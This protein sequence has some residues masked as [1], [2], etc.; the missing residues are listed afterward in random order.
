M[1]LNRNFQHE[2]QYKNISDSIRKLADVR[3]C[4]DYF[5]L[6]NKKKMMKDLSARDFGT[7]N[8][9]INSTGTGSFGQICKTHLHVM[10]NRDSDTNLGDYVYH[11]C[12]TRKSKGAVLAKKINFGKLTAFGQAGVGSELKGLN[13]D[14]QRKVL[15]QNLFDSLVLRN[16]MLVEHRNLKHMEGQV[17]MGAPGG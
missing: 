13:E 17:V 4:A 6:P 1:T 16:E 14:E 11:G 9:T 8:V 5:L 2:L 3:K 15:D 10:L 12:Y 7:N